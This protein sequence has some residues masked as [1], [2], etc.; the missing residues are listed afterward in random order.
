[1]VTGAG[2]M[3][4]QDAVEA[5]ARRRHAVYDLTRAELDVTDT[6]AVE[7][8]IDE[9]RALGGRQFDPHLVELFLALVSEDL[10]AEM[11]HTANL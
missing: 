2:G 9:I 6:A 7:D 10:P 3:L 4:G 8:A 5:I 1:M 11:V